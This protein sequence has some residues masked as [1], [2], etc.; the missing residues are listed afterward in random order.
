[1]YTT[2]VVGAHKSQTARRAVAEAIE[3]ARALGPTY[4]SSR[5]IPRTMARST[6]R[7]VPAARKHHA[8]WTSRPLGRLAGVHDAHAP[9]RPGQSVV[10]GRE[11]R[12]GRPHRRRQQGDE[13]QGPV[14]R[15]RP[16]RHRA[17]GTLRGPHRL[18]DLR[19]RLRPSSACRANSVRPYDCPRNPD[20]AP[21][22][23]SRYSGGPESLGRSHEERRPIGLTG[24]FSR[25][26]KA[27]Q[28]ASVTFSS[29]GSSWRSPPTSFGRHG[30]GAVAGAAVGWNAASWFRAWRQHAEWF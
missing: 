29:L 18:L 8:R 10:T 20:Q 3:L 7:T 14:P 26:T 11:G 2:I 15:Q 21:W 5:P 1:M 6:A 25:M 12:S 24:R 4:T 9:R 30:T 23:P 28:R 16:Q 13:G 19:P 27:G 22:R 17:P